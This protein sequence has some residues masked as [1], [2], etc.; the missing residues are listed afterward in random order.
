MD[1]HEVWLSAFLT[2]SKKEICY[3]SRCYLT[4]KLQKFLFG[5]Q[6]LRFF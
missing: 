1:E 2:A 4:A 6:F 5:R 3:K